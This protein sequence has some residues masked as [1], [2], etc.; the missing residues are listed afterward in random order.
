M[1]KRVILKELANA[2]SGDKGNICNIGLI[3]KK[4]VNYNILLKYVTAEKVKKH[5]GDYVKGDVIRYEMPNV[6]ALNFVL[7]QSLNG[8]ALSSLRSDTLGK[9]FGSGLLKMEL[10]IDDSDLKF[11]EQD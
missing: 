4:D 6:S 5:F 10:N 8:G 9:C 2:L 1:G 7:Y 3:A 11:I